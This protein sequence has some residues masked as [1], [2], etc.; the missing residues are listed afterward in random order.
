MSA[1]RKKFRSQDVHNVYK[2]AYNEDF[3]WDKILPNVIK[4]YFSALHKG[5][6]CPIQFVMAAMLA[7]VA[8]MCGPLSKIECHPNSQQSSLNLFFLAVSAP[9]GGKSATFD[10]IITP[11][12]EIFLKDTGKNFLLENYTHAGMQNHQ[13]ECKGM[14]LI[15]SD[16]GIR[17]MSSIESKQQK[18]E[19]E[20]QFLCK[21][22]TGKGDY[23]VL[24]EKERG[25]PA[26][27]TSILLFVQPQPFMGELRNFECN[28]GLLDRFLILAAMPFWFMSNIIAENAKLLK[29]LYQNIVTKVFQLIYNHHKKEGEV[30]KFSDDAQI[31]YNKICDDFAAEFNK[32]YEKGI[33]K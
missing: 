19:G 33:C 15:A 3:Q 29:D 10:Q 16:E 26:T 13:G 9:G 2:T 11:A 14:G 24:K 12:A 1:K 30:Y 5:A 28:D 4:N 7:V 21:T 22:W 27:S 18:N 31:Y 23:T 6:G 20:R 8:S 32:Q 25:Y 17:V